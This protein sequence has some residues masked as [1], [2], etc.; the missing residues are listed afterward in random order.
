LYVNTSPGEGDVSGPWNSGE[1]WEVMVPSAENT[2]LDG[3]DGTASVDLT[4]DDE[5]AV[6]A[7]AARGASDPSRD[8][9][10]GADLGV[11]QQEPKK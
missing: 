3:G 11:L 10:T 8:P 4:G 7:F 5:T 2:P 9:V 1:N 6:E